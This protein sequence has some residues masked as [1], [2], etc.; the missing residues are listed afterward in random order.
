MLETIQ[1]KIESCT[2]C[3]RCVRECPMETA[4]VTYQ[5][6]DGNIKVKIDHEKCISCGRCV[7]ACKHKSRFYLDDTG[8]FFEDLKNGVSISLIAAPSVRTNI[9]GYKNLFTYLKQL[10]V[11][12]I[13]D[14]SLGADICIWAH[15]RYLEKHDAA[16]VIAQCCPAV[17][18]Y[19][20]LYRHDLLSKLSPIHSPMACT[21]IF[22]KKYCGIND[23]IAAISPCVAKKNEFYDTRLAQYNITFIKLLEYLDKNKITLPAEESDFD[24]DESGMGCLFPMPG[25][26]KENIEFI[27]D[28][29]LHITKAEGY[30]LYEKLNRYADTSAEL[31]PD[32]FDVLNCVEG[33]NIGSASSHDGNIFRIDKTMND[34]RKRAAE[35]YKKENYES[36]F[37]TYDETFDLSQFYREYKPVS[38]SFPEIS[39]DDID[40]A[41]KLLDK[42]DFEKQNVDCGACGSDTCRNMARKI[43]LGVNI[44]V[45]C[46]VKSMEDARQEHADKLQAHAQI[47]EMEKMRESDE[48]MRLML[49]TTPLC[50]HIWDENANIIDCNQAAVNMFGLPNK[51]EYIKRYFELIPEFQPDGV[52]STDKVKLIIR[53]ALEHGHQRLEWMRKSIDGELIPVELTLV[54]VEFKGRKFITGYN[55]D[56]RDYKKMLK[57]LEEAHLTASAMLE[58]NPQVNM[59]FDQN[60]NV[61]NCNPAA[62]RFMGFKTKEEMLAGA[63][64]RITEGIPVLQPDG[65]PSIP[66]DWGLREAVEKGLVKFNSNVI[67]GQ[68]QLNL[69]VEFIRI[70]YES[71]YAV[72]CYIYDMTN[73]R[74]RENELL[75]VHQLNELQLTKLNMVVKASKIGLWD[76]EVVRDDPLNPDNVFVWSNEFRQFLGFT[77]EEDFPNRMS[78]IYGYFHPDDAKRVVAELT[79]HMRDKT[80]KTPFDAEYRIKR[81]NGEYGYFHA[82]GETIRDGEGNP[83]RAAGALIDVTENK[84]LLREAERQRQEAEAANRAKSAFLST[85]SHEIRTPMN[86]ILGITEIMLQNGALLPDMKEA[87]EKIH[88]SGDL[89]L[90]IINDILDLSKIEAGKMEIIVAKYEIS[91][92]ISDTAQLNIMHIGSKP[93]AFNLNVNENI[94]AAL[95]GDEL[96][97]K[98]ILNNIL[99]NAFKYTKDGSVKMLVSSEPAGADDE[100][101]LVVSIKDTG[102]GITKDQLVKLYD[103]YARF[104]IEANRST[105]GTGL[106]MSITKK[107]I[108]MMRGEITIESERGKGTAITLR[109]PQRRA[110]PALLGRE[111]AESLH[112]F[113]ISGKSQMKR[114]QISRDPMPYG[115]VLIVD[116]V[117]TN[118][119]VASGL[120]WPY[121]L[122]IDSADSGFAAIEKIRGGAVYDIVFMDHM[123]PK[124]DGIEATKIIRGMGYRH[125][126][127]ALTANAV[128]GQADIFLGNGFDDYISK[129]IDIRQLNSILNRLIRDKQPPE[130]IAEARKQSLAG[131]RT[132]QQADAGKLPAEAFLRDAKK[133]IAALEALSDKNDY[134]DEGNLR[135]YVI[136]THGIKS[137]LANMGNME[138]SAVAMKL[139]MAGRGG[140][141]ETITSATQV[142]LEALRAFTEVI[143]ARNEENIGGENIENNPLLKEKLLVIRAACENYDEI[144]ADREL[145][146]LRKIAWQPEIKALLDT[147]SDKLLHS[148]FTEIVNNLDLF[149]A[150][151]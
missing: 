62:I 92:L 64:Q 108:Q 149:L 128:A 54:R 118:I 131:S 45:N 72:V 19:C 74:E 57:E 33:C 17:V 71:S 23:S 11:N 133:A 9:P 39:E 83:V 106:G 100:V 5:D 112:H 34:S 82:T 16:P 55:R 8:R 47:S 12:K 129:P 142:F 46:I 7:S 90:G 80:G 29:K 75:R 63:I 86:A 146:I 119:Y 144:V 76:M 13:F 96:R 65:S 89:L 120:M 61:I 145:A 91:S 147:I 20:E 53:D 110:G 36:L 122:K 32:L 18:K 88:N 42:T 137:A 78:S 3:N 28:K 139:E 30:S 101:S 134:G 125:P 107:L 43:A 138:L 93:V 102:Q 130:I 49:D 31:L 51:E 40:M 150:T 121:R 105:Q 126:I 140:D 79:A 123:M 22:I 115:S 103:E 111:V 148:D 67:F 41:Y 44:P 143:K 109:I 132:P 56:L 52:R 99:S 151:R 87:L 15:I 114:V 25:G 73:L 117:E 59:L 50:A 98:Q 37:K 94:P 2:G 68:R 141:L 66:L 69:D 127:V 1:V 84:N 10:G 26:L 38:V 116:D 27:M 35:K 135:S 14:V 58:S 104:N 81:K 124:M 6:E 113:R 4:N 85:M 24:H 60:F 48:R 21:S 136:N 95:I 70:P 77:D 97:I